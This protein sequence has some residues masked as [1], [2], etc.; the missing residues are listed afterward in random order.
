MKLDEGTWGL[1]PT[2]RLRAADLPG[3]LAHSGPEGD[4]AVLPCAPS[5]LGRQLASVEALCAILSCVGGVRGAFVL[6]IVFWT[7]CRATPVIMHIVFMSICVAAQ[8][9]AFGRT[10][11]SKTFSFLSWAPDAH[12]LFGL[13][14]TKVWAS[15]AQMEARDPSRTNVRR[16]RRRRPR[17]NKERCDYAATVNR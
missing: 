12:V 8:C 6:H 10:A 7:A 3:L 15:Q 17:Q 9:E 11:V 1:D 16:E 14:M 13:R 2:T 4:E 5:L